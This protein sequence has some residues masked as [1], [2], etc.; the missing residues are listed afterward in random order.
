MATRGAS[1]RTG[2]G[3]Y[4]G[5]PGV[6]SPTAAR[7]GRR[8]RRVVVTVLGASLLWGGLALAG[9]VYGWQ[10]HAHDAGST[11]VRS[12]RTITHH[13]AHRRSGGPCVVAA[14]QPGQLAGILRIPALGLIAPVEEGTTDATLGVAV[15]HD[16]TSVWP[17]ATGTAVLLAHDV[18][19]FVHLDELQPGDRIVYRTACTTVDY[20]VSGQQVVQQGTPV[21]NATTPTLVLDTCY[22]SNALFFT[23]QRLLVRAT[24]SAGGARTG[25]T[26]GRTSLDPPAVDGVS[27]SVP[28]PAPLVAQGLTLQQNEAPMGTMTLSG[29]PSP[30]WEQSPGPLALESAALEAYFGGIHAAAQEQTSWWS[31]IAE[32]GVAPPAPLRGAEIT[33]HT[34]PLDV[35]I[36]SSGGVPTAVTL[37]TTVTVSGGAAPGTYAE[38]VGTTVHGSTVRIGGWAMTAV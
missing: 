4:A 16:A 10:H 21:P 13:V 8:R 9:Y 20:T 7:A 15:G 2:T 1:G 3:S 19:Y 36:T 25:A 33:G 17:G 14:P 23:T 11:L 6:A 26:S 12:E 24:E 35:Q 5:A 28:A 29:Q 27:Y 30:Q 22:P 34:A 32:P 37:T 18:S 38:T 31:A